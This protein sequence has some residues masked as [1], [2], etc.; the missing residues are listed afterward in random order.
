MVQLR[1]STAKVLHVVH[2]QP[3]SWHTLFSRM[4]EVLKVSLVTYEEWVR[5][6]RERLTSCSKNDL[7]S[8]P[9]LKLLDFFEEVALHLNPATHAMV[10]TEV[11][12]KQAV[13]GSQA[14]AT[15]KALTPEDAERWLSYWSGLGLL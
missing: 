12:V 9:A 3:A 4:S 13:A 2:P 1:H 8:I 6:L 5:C 11:S 10:A 14:L 15:A 7:E